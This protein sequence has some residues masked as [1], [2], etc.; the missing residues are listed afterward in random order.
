MKLDALHSEILEQLQRNARVSNT[1]IAHQVGISSP[2]VTERIKK[3]EDAGIIDGYYAKVA[4]YELGYDLRALITMRAFMGRLQPFLH[5]VVTLDEV[6]NCYRITGNENIVME[7][8]LQNQRHLE[9][10]IDQLITYGE[11]KT[12]IILS[13]VVSNRP[14]LRK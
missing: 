7:V 10:L 14:I 12:Q 4:H 1:A 8:V 2:A 13:N 11:T 9:K 5:K 6:I 3:L